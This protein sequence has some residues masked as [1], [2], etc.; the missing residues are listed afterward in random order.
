MDMWAFI[1]TG[2]LLL[3]GVSLSEVAR[4]YRDRE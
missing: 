1:L 3:L 4:Q 2:V